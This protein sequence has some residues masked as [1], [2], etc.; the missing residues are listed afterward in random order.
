MNV[1]AAKDYLNE[2]P[3][4]EPVFILRGQDLLAASTIRYWCKLHELH[5][6]APEKRE[7]AYDV[8]AEMMNW[9]R[10]KLPD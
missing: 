7:Q 4:D 6:G 8:A 9:G 1:K 10:K 5:D 2:I 3:D